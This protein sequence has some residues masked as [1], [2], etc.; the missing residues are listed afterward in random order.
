MT[1]SAD[2]QTLFD[3][4]GGEETVERMVDEFYGRV[5]ADTALQ[6]FFEQTSME[7]L[8]RMQREFFG[9]ALGGPIKYSGRPLNEAHAGKGIKIGHFQRYVDHLLDTLKQFE[10][11]DREVDG[12]I[13]HVSAYITDITG[14]T[15]E[16]G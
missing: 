10:L 6:P 7:K 9:A 16:D 1:E 5:T 3:R 2:D 11:N 15:T 4:L 12:I 14:E 13:D 8:R